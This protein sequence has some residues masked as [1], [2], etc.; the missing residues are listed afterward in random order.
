M[1]FQ[2]LIPNRVAGRQRWGVMVLPITPFLFGLYAGIYVR[3]FSPMPS[4]KNEDN[5]A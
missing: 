5:S 1:V 2:I 3:H 4:T